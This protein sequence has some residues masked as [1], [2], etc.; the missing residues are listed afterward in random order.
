MAGQCVWVEMQENEHLI[1]SCQLF[2][3]AGRLKKQIQGLF[4]FLQFWQCWP[5]L[6]ILTYSE[7]VYNT[8]LTILDM[9]YNDN[10]NPI[11]FSN[12]WEPDFMKIFVTW[13]LRETL[14]WTAFAILA[15]FLPFLLKYCAD[16]LN[17]NKL[18]H[19]SFLRHHLHITPTP[20]CFEIWYKKGK[21]KSN[22]RFEILSRVVPLSF[23]PLC[24]LMRGHT[25]SSFW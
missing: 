19:K 17:P 3:T 16:S 8:V 1:K 25:Y 15:S 9:F 7:L 13:Q 5:F 11:D 14:H 6:T 22:F 18:A 21:T 23:E 2:G 10:D 12:N 20:S 4:L 24:G